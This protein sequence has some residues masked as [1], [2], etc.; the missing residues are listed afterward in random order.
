M[1]KKIQTTR[2]DY[3]IAGLAALAI[4]IHIA[5][6]ALPSPIPGMKLGLANVIT[7]IALIRFGWSTALWISLLRVFVGSILIGT[8][9]S[10]TFMLSLAGAIASMSGLAVIYHLLHTSR[11]SPGPIGYSIIAALGHMAGQFFVAYWLFIPH[12]GLF[13]LLP[14]LMS[15]SLIFGIISGIIVLGI[16]RQATLHTQ[17]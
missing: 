9:L 3:R 2:Q 4:T 17:R 8:F 13:A 11:A 14:L 6:M 5:E 10:P 12:A 15:A 1:T 16:N 7:I